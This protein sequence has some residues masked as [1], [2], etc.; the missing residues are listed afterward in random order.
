MAFSSSPNPKLLTTVILPAVP[1]VVTT[2]ASSTVPW[3][4][5]L[6]ASSEYSGSGLSSG[7]G[8][9]T[10][11]PT[12]YT[13]PPTPPPSPGPKPPPL[14]EPTP[15]PEP[16]PMPP[17][18]P[19]P[20]DGGPILASGSPHTFMFTLGSGEFS[21]AMMVGSISSLG[22]GLFTT[23]IGGVNCRSDGRGS[24]P[25]LAGSGDRSP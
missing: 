24:F 2:M 22:F 8:A 20:F 25:L 17:P 5:A 9:V 16:E 21:G 15:P 13:P 1:L 10:P 3:Y 18:E 14:P 23:A 7:M 11:P 19:G 12:L 6:R 4:L